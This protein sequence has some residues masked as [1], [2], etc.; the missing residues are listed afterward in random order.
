MPKSNPLRSPLL[1]ALPLPLL[2]ALFPA[3]RLLC[4][5]WWLLTHLLHLL[6]PSTQPPQQS[7]AV[8]RLVHVGYSWSGLPKVSRRRAFAT[9]LGLVGDRC[10][11]AWVASWGGH[12]GVDK[13]VCLFDAARVDAL[14]LEGHPIRPGDV[15]DNLLVAGLPWK[16]AARPGQRL[17]ICRPGSTRGGG[18]LLEISEVT[19]PC[20]TTKPPFLK[21]DNSLMD[22]RKHPGCSRWYA[23]VL[24]TGWLAPG[25]EV[26]W[27]A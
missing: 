14:R 27:L 15:G 25:D 20:G 9:P 24:R 26:H 12:G 4:Q 3:A 18:V 17:R 10:R 13:A 6:L 21:G 23:R 16:E 2:N 5:L 1:R 19:A 11:S 8:G 7:R 22:E